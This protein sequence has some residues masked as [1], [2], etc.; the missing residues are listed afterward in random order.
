MAGATVPPEGAA[1]VDRPE[2]VD[3][4]LGMELVR[5]TEAAALSAAPF[6]GR[7]DGKAG[8]QAAV[9][10]MRA[11]LRTV[12]MTG[13]VIIGEGEKDDA[14][15]LYNGEEVGSGD[16]PELDLAVDPVEGTRLLALGRPNAIAVIA[17]SP[18]GSMWNPGGSYYAAKLVVEAGA[19]DAVDI[20]LPVSEN[21]RRTAEALGRPVDRLT[22]FVLDKPRH[23]E[24]VREIRAAGARVTLH[25]DGDVMGA[26]LAAYPDTGVDLLMGTGGTPEAVIAAAAVKALGGGMQ[27]RRDPQSGEERGRLE[28]EGVDVD[29]VLGLDELIS[30]DDAFFS[31]T[32]ITGSPFLQGVRYE[33][34]LGVSTESLVIRAGSGSIRH[35]RGMHR[36]NSEH[37]FGD[38][39]GPEGLDQVVGVVTN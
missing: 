23:E 37:I 10:A 4:N 8:D 12:R 31:A 29:E 35:I 33:R 34:G 38:G 18:A 9:N 6:M 13:T 25:T 36:L 39:R 19:R 15:M 20:R 26:L 27:V 32:A 11:V 21:L 17:A 7:G 14:P 1:W 2:R 24:L 16:S 30:S 3:R 5:V 28:K 22:V